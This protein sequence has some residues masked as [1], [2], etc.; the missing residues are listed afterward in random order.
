MN[1]TDRAGQTTLVHG[2]RGQQRQL[3][4]IRAPGRLRA[5]PTEDHQL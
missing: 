3:N 4:F 2:R 5:R 1:A